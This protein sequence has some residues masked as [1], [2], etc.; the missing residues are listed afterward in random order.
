MC[1]IVTGCK[2]VAQMYPKQFALVVHP[3]AVGLI[4]AGTVF[5]TS[6]EMFYVVPLIVGT[7]GLLYKIAWL[8]TIFIVFNLLGNMLACYRTD[9]SVENLPID[10]QVPTPE[11][12][13]LWHHCDYCQVL[14]PILA[15]QIV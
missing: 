2:Y 5:F 14:R 6:V 1:F 10:R 15:L 8:V 11:E 4:L 13:H 9:S 12:E 3:C 7:E